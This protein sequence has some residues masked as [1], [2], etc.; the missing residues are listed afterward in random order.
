MQMNFSV[1]IKC[2]WLVNNSTCFLCQKQCDNN[3]ARLFKCTKSF[4]PKVMSKARVSKN[5]LLVN[6]WQ[7][8]QL[9]LSQSELIFEHR[10]SKCSMTVLEGGTWHTVASL[11][12]TP[13]CAHT[14]THTQVHFMH[15]PP[16]RVPQQ[17]LRTE[18]NRSQKKAKRDKK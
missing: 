7:S 17:Q 11:S 12:Q 18:L 10:V 13:T 4:F 14:H 16:R 1:I 9:V 2:Y 8:C 15:T 3:Q 6:I 5:S